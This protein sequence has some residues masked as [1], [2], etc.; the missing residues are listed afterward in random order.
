MPAK[1]KL[2]L[3]VDATVLND[4]KKKAAEK[5]VPLSRAVENFFKFFA[6]PEVYCFRCGKKFSSDKA[7]LCP[8]CGWLSCPH[9]RVCRCDLNE[10]T[11]VAVFY[12][13]KVLEDLLTGRVK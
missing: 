7:E 3:S 9:C 2:T 10:D 4:A 5:H 13:R 11:A 1:S 8:K 12:M 6:T